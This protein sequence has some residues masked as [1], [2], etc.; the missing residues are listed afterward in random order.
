[1]KLGSKKAPGGLGGAASGALAGLIAEEGLKDRE[2]EEAAAGANARSA[3]A[4]VQ[5]AARAAEA[6]SA[7]Q[8]LVVVEEKV[9]ARI[10]RDGGCLG[11]EVKGS[12]SL[13]LHDEA[14]AR[15]R[16][17]FKRGDDSG[18]SFQSHPNINKAALGAP[19]GEGAIAHKQADR[20]FPT[21]A[22]VGVLRWRFTSK[23]DDSA[24]LP[25]MIT[26]WPEATGGGDIT[27]NVEYSLQAAGVALN[28]VIVSVPLGTGGEAPRV[29]SCDGVFKHNAREGVLA[30]R[31]ET[32]SSENG[33]GAMEFTVKAGR[34]VTLDSFFPVKVSF[35][36]ADT[37]VGLR[38]LDVVGADDGKSLRHS[39]QA[40]MST[41]EYVVE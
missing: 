11:Y 25:L 18:F 39:A 30:W 7:D 37:L 20:A 24:Q 35:S 33:S 29:Q 5:A 1:M 32:I 6:A 3:E 4:A 16:V 28:D 23:D 34:G 26:C 41:D 31:V 27:V 40:G 17:L 38:V 9:A 12:L 8:A 10:S 13:T 22:A 15:C 19:G 2:A 14:A 21:G 36:S